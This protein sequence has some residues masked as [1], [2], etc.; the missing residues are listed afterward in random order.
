ME[1]E[2]QAVRRIDVERVVHCDH[3][4]TLAESDRNHFE[5]PRIFAPD[6]VDDSRRND[7]GRDIDP[8]HLRL[9]GQR[10]RD[11]HLGHNS[12]I[13]QNIDHARLA[14]QARAGTVDLLACD[15]YYIAE[16]SEYVLFVLLHWWKR[17]ERSLTQT[18]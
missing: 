4:S 7:H 2:T 15:Q 1:Q 18:A 3:Q 11:V 10:A 14:V 5:A 9:R 13:D 16:D 12:V 17:L 6:L 8:V